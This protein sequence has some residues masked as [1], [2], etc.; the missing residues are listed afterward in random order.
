MSK[1]KKTDARIDIR[2]ALE[3]PLR[4]KQ[5]GKTK[6]MPPYE[7]MLR[8]HTKKALVDRSLLSLK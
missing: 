6:S 4:L 1:R 2:G 3:A 7:A 8:Q 5:G